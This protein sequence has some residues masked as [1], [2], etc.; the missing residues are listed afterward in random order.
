MVSN[1]FI[2]VV[3]NR[4]TVNAFAKV[5]AGK[6]LQSKL[7]DSS[8]YVSCQPSTTQ[9]ELFSHFNKQKQMTNCN[10]QTTMVK[11]LCKMFRAD[12]RLI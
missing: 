7:S 2:S 11:T 4:R 8:C 5:F 12:V 6:P 10:K 9:P 1:Q 3:C